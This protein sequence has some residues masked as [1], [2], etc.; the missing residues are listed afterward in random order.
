[1]RTLSVTVAAVG[2]AALLAACG[3]A[4]GSESA[5]T[6]NG[7]ALAIKF[8]DCMRAHGVPD[9]PDPGQRRPADESQ[10]SPAFQSAS[11]ICDRVVPNGPPP[12]PPS[13]SRRL[14]ALRF[15]Q[16]MRAHGVPNFPDPTIT[17]PASTAP[18]LDLAG[19]YFALPPGLN[20]KAPAVQRGRRSCR[21]LSLPPG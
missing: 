8:A 7:N 14:A 15:A 12:A 21:Q 4:G 2:A 11:K 13:A 18:T 9:F 1:V 3:G 6:G 16:C 10:D 5:A 20:L 19:I 17:P